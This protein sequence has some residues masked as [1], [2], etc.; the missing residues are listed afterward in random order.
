MGNK[1]EV[2]SAPATPAHGRSDKVESAQK[3]RDNPKTNESVVL[4]GNSS[5][6]D[7]RSG[8]QDPKAN[9]DSQSHKKSKAKKTSEKSNN[10]KSPGPDAGDKNSMHADESKGSAGGNQHAPQGKNKNK[11]KKSDGKHEASMNGSSRKADE[12]IFDMKLAK[13]DWTPSK[14]VYSADG[15]LLLGACGGRTVE[16]LSVSGGMMLF[17]L[18]DHKAAVTDIVLHPTKDTQVFTSSFDGSIRLW[19]L[20]RGELVKAWK[21]GYPI[22]HMLLSPDGKKAYVSSFKTITGGRDAEGKLLEPRITCA[23]IEIVLDTIQS[24]RLFKCKNIARLAMSTDGVLAAVS[25]REVYVWR[26]GLHEP[27]NFVHGSFL[28]SPICVRL[29]VR[30]CVLVNP[31]H[32]RHTRFAG[33]SSIFSC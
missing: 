9:Q 3:K 27:G 19:D 32:I 25:H 22:R 4:N 1:R 16:V 15:K 18:Q 26:D 20:T 17:E 12:E 30:G 10:A 13:G 14:I 21:C 33:I 11:Q 31:I 7:K 5:E 8:M 6:N 23:V 24:R 28:K 2:S 29:C